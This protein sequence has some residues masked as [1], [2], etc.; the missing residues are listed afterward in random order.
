M[1]SILCSSASSSPRAM[2]MCAI[3]AFLPLA[4]KAQVAT[5]KLGATHQAFLAALDKADAAQRELQS[6]NAAPY[7]AI[8]SQSDEATLIG[9]FGGG[10]EKGWAKVSQRI[11]WVASQFSNG[12]NTIERLVTQSSG[13]LG[14]VIQ[15]EH[16]RFQVPGQ[17]K[18]STRDYRVTMIFRRETAG[19]RLIHRHADSQMMKQAP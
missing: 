6:G 13:D 18:E 7:K 14:Y 10:V 1:L 17:T 5:E 19:W 12:T 16:L 15:V 11:D 8:W 3:V 9:G 2:R 4:A